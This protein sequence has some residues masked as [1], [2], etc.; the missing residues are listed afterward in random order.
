MVT[1]QGRDLALRA[2]CAARDRAGSA[3]TEW[4]VV[5]SGSTDGT[6]AA[7]EAAHPDT[8]VLRR[9]NVGFAAANNVGMRVA[10]GRYLLLLN[11]DMEIVS[12]TLGDL[13]AALDARP[14]VGVASVRVFLPDGEL[15]PTI[16][17]FPSP[18]R[19]LGEALFLARL[20]A[21]A[22]LR[23]EEQDLSTYLSE[24]SADWLVGAFLLVRREAFE[25]AGGMDER[26]FMF[27]EET[28]WCFRIRAAHW[29]IRHLPLMAAIHHTGRSSRPDLFAQ[30]SF[31]KLL[32]ARKHFGAL[33][34]TAFRGA[35]TTRHALR[36]VLL[37]PAALA[38]RRLRS[39][40][41]AERLALMVVL[42]LVPPP[43]SPA[44]E[45]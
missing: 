5:D 9:A 19:Q 1:H 18:G 22:H 33:R 23:E 39:R 41:T 16:K 26:F 37:A 31:A 44:G 25:A 24:A 42:G 2:L 6:P 35:L 45:G 36:V 32:Y 43:F 12:G 15:Q 27:S 7:I 34:R 11:P 21:L 20:P 28:D 29:E 8:V 4:I 30:N 40:L 38:R 10:R 14:E 17:R 3:R 13:V